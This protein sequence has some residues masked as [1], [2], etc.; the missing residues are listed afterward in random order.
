M[1]P[2]SS[3]QDRFFP[4]GACFGCGPKNIRGLRLRSFVEG[5][6]VVATWTPEECHA[7]VPDVLCGGIVST[8]LDCHTGAAM[9][10]AV[11]ERTGKWPFLEAAMWATASLSVELRRPTPIRQPLSLSARV[12]ALSD[13]EC[14][15]VAELESGGKLRAECRA[16]WRE[17]RGS[18]G[19]VLP[20]D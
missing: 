14:S 6:L 11:R 4:D 18:H 3:I 9:A 5:D 1:S 8:L 12:T 15:V 16:V 19:P 20:R 2:P 7:A 10:C 13:H 17:V